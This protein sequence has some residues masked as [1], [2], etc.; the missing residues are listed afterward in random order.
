MKKVTQKEQEMFEKAF[1][2]TYNLL[3]LKDW[4][5][6]FYYDEDIYTKDNAFATLKAIHS[7]STASVF[8][9]SHYEGNE[10]NPKKHG[11]HEAIELLLVRL[12]YLAVTRHVSLRE[13][14]R[15][16]HAIVQTLEKII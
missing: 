6:Y 5:V 7:S 9:T 12:F 14:T 11:K 4:Q 2:E 13:I 16:H 8:L 1:K 3:G 15:E 10:F